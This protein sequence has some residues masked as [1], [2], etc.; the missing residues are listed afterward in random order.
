MLI[1]DDDEHVLLNIYFLPLFMVALEAPLRDRSQ[2]PGR[3]GYSHTVDIF[4]LNLIETFPP[5]LAQSDPLNP[6]LIRE[7][8][9]EEGAR[10]LICKN[11]HGG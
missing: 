8:K 11:V 6:R 10:I 9:E 1:W 7:W 2:G 5:S 3:L 4:Y